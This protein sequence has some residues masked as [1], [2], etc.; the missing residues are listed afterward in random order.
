MSGPTPGPLSG[1]FNVEEY[2]ADY[3][4]RADEGSYSPTENERA[5]RVDAIHG[6]LSEASLSLAPAAPV[7]ASGSERERL[8]RTIDPYAWDDGQY[9][10]PGGKGQQWSQEAAR[11]AADRVLAL[12]PQPSGFLETLTDEQRIAALS[13]TG[14]DTHPQPSGEMLEQRFPALNGHLIRMASSGN[15]GSLTEWGAFI[16]CIHEAVIARPAPVASGCQH[17]SGEGEQ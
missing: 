14:G 2:V 7:E 8:A 5:L 12:R 13:H 9:A 16:N 10:E 3:E 6:A 1:D 11:K 17:S 15:T 4:F